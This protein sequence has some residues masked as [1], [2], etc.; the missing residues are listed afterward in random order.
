MARLADDRRQERIGTFRE[1]WKARL[2]RDRVGSPYPPSSLHRHSDAC[3]GEPFRHV[4]LG[5]SF[6]VARCKVSGTLKEL[7]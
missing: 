6:L 2:E 7:A 4:Y 5:K 3:W 1:E